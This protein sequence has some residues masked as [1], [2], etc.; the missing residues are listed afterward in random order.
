MTPPANR[1]QVPDRGPA[2]ISI[3]Q[4]LAELERL[5]QRGDEGATTHELAMAWGCNLQKARERIKALIGAGRVALGFKYATGIDGR[6][7]RV[8][9]YRLKQKGR[10]VK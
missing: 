5:A 4:W 6:R 7:T 1:K 8:P 10:D 9:V 3:D 2:G